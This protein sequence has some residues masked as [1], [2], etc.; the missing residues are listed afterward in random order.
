MT[1]RRRI[2]AGVVVII[3]ACLALSFVVIYRGTTANVRSAVDQ[4]LLGDMDAFSRAVTLSRDPYATARRYVA[5]QPF[6]ATTRLLYA[7]VP[8]RDAVSNEPELFG[9]QDSGELA[10]IVDRETREAKSVLA[11]ATGFHTFPVPDVGDLRLLVR[12]QDGVRLGIGEPLENLDRTQHSMRRTFLLAGALG[13]AAALLAAAALSLG[14]VAPL[15]R[16]AAVADRVGEG[17][18]AP[19]MGSGGPRDEVRALAAAFDTMLDRLQDAFDR[20][21]AFVAD[22]SHE[23]RTP[24]TVIRGQLEVLARDP[25]PRA[26]D[27]RHVE[28][29][30]LTEVERMGRMVDD[31]LVLAAPTVAARDVDLPSLLRELLDGVRPTADR[32]FELGHIPAEPVKA[33]P[34]RLAQ[35]VRNVLRNAVQHTAGGGTIRLDAAVGEGVI[36]ITV[37]DDGPGIPA[38]EHGKVFD[39]FHRASAGAPRTEGTGLGLSIV[40]AIVEAH[41]GQVRAEASPDL[42]G[43]RVVIELPRTKDGI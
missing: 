40:K 14:V 13:L 15:R 18:L 1:I 17:D 23:L 33:D 39:R 4:D 24:L 22:A 16:M 21:T 26:A 11:S 10:G 35:A 42:G 6:R 34:D 32:H 9:A 28:R 38:E 3:A 5:S 36:R 19:R 41:G 37:D 43:A 2:L 12:L 27:V 29:L 20:Q 31:L 8:G 30:V 7:V 25:N